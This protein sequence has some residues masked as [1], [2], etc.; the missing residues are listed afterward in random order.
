M[1]AMLGRIVNDYQSL[2]EICRQRAAE[3][4]ISRS[5]IDVISGLTT[6]H[7]GKILGKNQKKRLGIV[8]LGLMLETL[9]LKMLI[10]EDE[11]AARRTLALRKPV[12][13]AQQR[14][15]NECNLKAPPKIE[16][17]ETL[18]IA[19]PQKPPAPM[20]GHLR[21]IQGKRKGGQNARRYG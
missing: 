8:S 16:R 9:G 14:F 12:D 2:V 15:G 18:K 7:A 6:G 3:L 20:R 5:G 11:T 21:V 4:E 10:I 19:A 13:R 17:I 1:G